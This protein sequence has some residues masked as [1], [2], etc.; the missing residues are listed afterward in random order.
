MKRF[1][2]LLLV[3]VFIIGL[4]NPLQASSR[5]GIKH[6]DQVN[7]DWEVHVDYPVFE[8]LKNR[9]LQKEINEKIIQKLEDTSSEIRGAAEEMTGFP[10][11]YYEEAAVY[12]E[13][14]LYSVVLTSHISRGNNYTSTV[15]SLNFYDRDRGK[16]LTL[17]ELFEMDELNKQVKKELAKEPDTYFV[18]T[19][20]SVRP[21]T[22]FYIRG[23]MLN[24]VFNK[25]E[26]APGVYGTPEIQ[27]PLKRLKEKD[28][29]KAHA[30]F[31]SIS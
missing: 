29:E 13:K 18:K 12:R 3:C 5:Y 10:V 2:G 27:I 7:Q 31:P 15:T 30:P 16:V 14:Q 20:S 17:N 4:S 6:K 23:D 28:T 9:Q 24:L 1:L 25:F 19:F 11:L 26:I 21:N 8:A 22:A